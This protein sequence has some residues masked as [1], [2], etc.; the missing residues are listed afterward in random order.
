[1]SPSLTSLL[2]LQHPV[3]SMSARAPAPSFQ[4]LFLSGM[5]LW[6]HKILMCIDDG[7]NMAWFCQ[8]CTIWTSS[9]SAH[10]FC[11]LLSPQSVLLARRWQSMSL[12]CF[13]SSRLPTSLALVCQFLFLVN[14]PFFSQ[15]LTSLTPGCQL[16]WCQLPQ[17]S[18]LTFCLATLGL[19]F[20]MCC[21][22]STKERKEWNIGF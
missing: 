3:P 6:I 22:I 11:L 8:F 5:P 18:Y 1:M 10:T 17:V 19:I 7:N 2:S 16:A 12:Y 21:I 14:S 20:S 9:L 4:S 15:Q 13:I